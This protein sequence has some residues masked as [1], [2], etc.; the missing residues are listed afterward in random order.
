MNHASVLS[1]EFQDIIK[2]GEASKYKDFFINWNTF[3]EGNGTMT[4]DGYIQP[5]EEL[6][7]DMLFRKPG[8]PILMV[9][10]PD[11][12]NVPYWNTFYQE[13]RYEKVDAQDLMK[14]MD[15]QYSAADRKSV[16]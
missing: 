15:I 13:V 3:W 6:I 1:K 14:A 8:M 10:M 2:N 7:K 9:R 4:E 12:K 5:N 16:V 11:G